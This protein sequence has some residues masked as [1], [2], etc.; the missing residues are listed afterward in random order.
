MQLDTATLAMIRG[1]EKTEATGHVVYTRM[2]RHEKHDSHARVLQQIADD[3]LDHYHIWKRYTGTDIAPNRLTTSWYTLLFFVFGYTFVLRLM[4]KGENRAVKDYH[5]LPTTIPEITGIIGQEQKH[6]E[7]LISILDEERLQYVG[8]IVLG[9]NDALVE[10]TGS[11]A[12]FTFALTNTR[13]IALA[14]II[15]GV[16]ATLSMAASNFLAEKANANAHA[17]KASMYTG[18]AYLAT[19]IILIIPYLIFPEDRYVEALVTMLAFVIIVIMC[20]N[21][22]VAI[23]QNQPFWSRFGRMAAISLSVALISFLIGQL[24]KAVLGVDV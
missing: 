4:E 17:F 21:Y 13:L 22:Y 2:A 18:I 19:V 24:A 3:E 9:L 1:F 7:M 15:T 12:G 8:A 20:F 16:S 5:A 14:G 6:E 23:A 10:L 11:I